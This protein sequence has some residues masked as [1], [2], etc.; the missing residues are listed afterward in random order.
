MPSVAIFRPPL[1]KPRRRPVRAL[2]LRGLLCAT[3]AVFGAAAWAAS[4]WTVNGKDMPLVEFITQVAEITGKTVVVDPRVKNQEITVLSD[5]PLDGDGVYALF[6]TVLKVHGLG[7][8]EADGVVSV[9]QQAA[10]KHS[11]GPVTDDGELPADQLVTRVVPITYV[12]SAEVVKAMRPLIPQTGLITAIENPNVLIIADQAGNMRRVLSLVAELDVVDTDEVVRRELEHA[13]V[14][15]LAVVLEKI[16]PD[17][18]GNAAA[19]PQ[20]VLMVANERD[21]SLILKGKPHVIAETLRLI[22]KL[23]VPDESTNAS[24][25]IQLNH[26]DAVAVA[27]LL[28]RLVNESSGADPESPTAI[29]QAYESLNALIVRAD[30]GTMQEVVATVSQL[31]VRRAQVLIETAVVEISIAQTRTHGVEL[32]GGDRSSSASPVFSTTLSGVIGSVLQRAGTDGESLATS[33]DP[34]AVAAGFAS[35]TIALSRISGDGVFFGALVNALA[36]DT[37][38]NLLST[39]SVLTLDNE[40][41]TNVSGQ[42]IPFRTGSFTTT[43]DGASNPFQTINRENVGVEL[44]VTPHIHDDLSMRMA[45]KLEVGNVAD[46]DAL[47]GVGIGNSGFADIVTN[48]RS[49]ETTILVDDRQ[50][51]MLGGLIQD[52]YS[53]VRRRVPLLGDIPGLGRAFRSK[54]RTQVKRHLLMF[55]RPSVFLTA[56]DAAATAARR[57]QGIYRLRGTD[58]SVPPNLPDVFEPPAG[59]GDT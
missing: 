19:G 6:L 48:N 9:V 40:E 35:P 32:A 55:L 5:V 29:I 30:P 36:S 2:T 53:N 27:E 54:R 28:D 21:N 25:V 57:F 38:A 23:D 52:D 39:P 45:I 22:D 14:G 11:S 51:I 50:I 20:R 16:A 3:L 24:Q 46:S 59:N 31:D 15:T 34:L 43:T 42:Q 26:A 10:T 44:T 7:A 8:V 56:E 17:R 12:P 18:I 1:R 33:I 4:S 58:S 37:R 13:W 41:A 49:L 47:G